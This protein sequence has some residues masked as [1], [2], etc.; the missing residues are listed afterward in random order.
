MI[1]TLKQILTILVCVCSFVNSNYAQVVTTSDNAIIVDGERY[2]IRGVCYS[3]RT[4]GA[5][6]YDYPDLG[7]PSYQAFANDIQMMNAACINTIRTYYGIFD[8]TRLDQLN[9]AGIKVIVIFPHADQRSGVNAS[10]RYGMVDNSYRNY[11]NTYKNH[12]AILMWGFGNEMNYYMDDNTWYPQLESA[13]QWV[14]ANDPNHPVT[15]ANGEIPTESMYND[16]CPSVDV[17]GANIYRNG[18][19]NTAIGEY[20]AM[21]GRKPFW[22]SEIGVDSY[23]HNTNGVDEEAQATGITN[24]WGDIQYSLDNNGICSGATYFNWT[25]EWWKSGSPN[26]Q[27]VSGSAPAGSFYPDGITDEEYYGLLNQ[28]RTPKKAYFALK[29]LWA[30]VCAVATPASFVL[31]D[32]ECN[33]HLGYTNYDGGFEIVNNPN[34]ST[35]NNS[36]KCVKYDRAPI[37]YAA[38]V[39]TTPQFSNASNFSD[40]L[41]TPT[42]DVY[43]SEA[44][45]TVTLNLESSSDIGEPY[46]TGRF[47][48][49][50]ATTTKTNQWETLK[51]TLQDARD[52]TVNPTDVD[53]IAILFNSGATND[54]GT[55]YF[56]NIK[57]PTVASFTDVSAI[58]IKN[59]MTGSTC[60]A[61]E[62]TLVVTI[63]NNSP[64][65]INFADTYVQVY[66]TITGTHNQSFATNV[67]TGTLNSGAT[68]DITVT[69]QADFSTNGAYVIDAGVQIIGDNVCNNNTVSTNIFSDICVGLKDD[70]NQMLIKLYPN[71]SNSYLNLDFA[72]ANI[73]T[74][75]I[76]NN[77]GQLLKSIAV[78]RKTNLTVPL[79][80]FSTGIYLIKV[81]S[82]ENNF[83]QR[84]QVAK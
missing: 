19:A 34:P 17:W 46:P 33:R 13:A 2:T 82:T 3:P 36:S 32:F 29:E 23:N 4:V 12:P 77:H 26:F 35:I 73:K 52:E 5:N 8:K 78:E 18:V 38:L 51:F 69:D 43:S 79:Q 22:Y 7:F 31:E 11:I 16:F 71:P 76:Y 55:Y 75:E 63:K 10:D 84:F 61:D 48:V 41:L 65:S 74:V 80:E 6:W 58:S 62:N 64:S 25:D 30:S 68:R 81:I 37:Q 24:M 57:G 53:R 28:N 66:A 42:M 50:T 54:N 39:A 15:T 44:N 1:K 60:I 27:N 9:A 40:K 67:L 59:P 14:H 47:A 49:F 83:I 70:H 20:Y 21:G 56:D 72:N 45:V